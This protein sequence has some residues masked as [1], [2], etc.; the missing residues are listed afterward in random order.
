[1][2]PIWRPIIA[3]AVVI[4]IGLAAAFYFN[5]RETKKDKSSP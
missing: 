4:A 1:M 2:D 3:F 5:R